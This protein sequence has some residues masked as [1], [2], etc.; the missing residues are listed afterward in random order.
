MSISDRV[1]VKSKYGAEYRR[2]SINKEDYSNF[3]KFR[4]KI[5]KIHNLPSTDYTIQ[6]VNPVDNVLLPITNDVTLENAFKFCKYLLRTLLLNQGETTCGGSSQSFLVKKDAA[7]IIRNIEP[8]SNITQAHINLM[9][10]FRPVSSII[11]IDL[12]PETMRRVRLIRTGNKPLGFY[13]RDGISY[14]TTTGGLERVP[15]I[16]I[17][18]L[19][20]DGLAESTGL[21][22]VHDEIIEVN[23]IEVRGKSL[24]QVTDIMVANSSHLIITVKPANQTTCLKPRSSRPS[25]GSQMTVSNLTNDTA[26]FITL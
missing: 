7:R 24:D 10:D 11:D 17:S 16:F 6:Y 18:R 3:V 21:L 13:I 15:G 26:G 2:F 12:V 14:R 8:G 20:K 5:F 19:S 9:Q 25:I 23:G 22:A 1:E 4:D